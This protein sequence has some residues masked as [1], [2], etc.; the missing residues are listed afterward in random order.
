MEP[1]TQNFRFKIASSLNVTPYLT[2]F[3][4]RRIAVTL[5]LGFASGLPLALTGS[6]LQAW[7][8]VT[9]VNLKTIG[10]F[11]LAGLPYT[12]KF[13]W[14]PVMDRFVP[15]W[16]GRRR[17]WILATQLVL[18]AGIA[19]L[20][21]LS[22]V[23]RPWTMAVVAVMVAFTS[24]SQDVVFD[25]YRTDMLRE[26]ERGMGAAVSVLGYRIAMLVSGALALIL[27]DRIGWQPTYWLMAG[28]MAV[29][30]MATV[31][32]PEPDAEVRPP[33]TLVE[34]V[35]QPLKDFFSRM[36]AFRPPTVSGSLPGAARMAG[37]SADYAVAPLRHAA[38]A[39]YAA[40]I[41]FLLLIVLYKL[42]D[43]FAGSLTSAFLIRG[44]GFS[45]SEVGMINKAM[46]MIATI[47]GVIL[48][49]TAMVKLGLLRALLAFG[50]LQAGSILTFMWLAVA[51]KSYPLMA[52]AVAAENFCGG[53]GTTAFVALLMA[54]CNARYT[55]TQYALLSALAAIGRV[56]VGPAAGY[57]TD[58]AGA[59]M[60]WSAFFF[61]AFLAALPGLW[62]VW[63]LR[64]RIV[65][66]SRRH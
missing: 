14:A 58:P 1:A 16:L 43:A 28:L 56:Y 9:G 47:A 54:L 64:A 31:L 26:N 46:G 15:P 21:S 32:G 66:L 51:G 35:W 12:W 11:T 30:M 42:G 60:P 3:R 19:L 37:V 52:F 49:G 57:L 33:A 62:L 13:L 8:A 36:A 65:N 7:M 23:E 27:A 25:A 18:V 20:G 39:D 10:I 59:A 61:C 6:T 22:P 50:I 5:W 34:A 17:G 63:I 44:A 45:P 2:V 55:A 48:G 24:A 41:L 29:C 38:H 53:L 40:P 4:S